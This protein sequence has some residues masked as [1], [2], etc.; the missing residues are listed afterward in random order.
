MSLALYLTQHAEKRLQQRG[1]RLEAV[2]LLMSFGTV[3]FDHNGACIY[4]IDKCSRRRVENQLGGRGLRKLE[5]IGLLYL[6][7]S[8]DGEIITVGHRQ[9]RIYRDRKPGSFPWAGKH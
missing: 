8:G 5:A 4:Y 6:V 1:I 2:D 3:E 9:R 7:A